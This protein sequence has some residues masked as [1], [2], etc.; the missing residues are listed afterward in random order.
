[1]ADQTSATG[2]SPLDQ[3]RLPEAD[4]TRTLVTA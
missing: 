4:I 3:I 1:M 2:L